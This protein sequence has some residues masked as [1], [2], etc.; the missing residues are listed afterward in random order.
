MLVVFHTKDFL[1]LSVSRN[2]ALAGVGSQHLLNF[3]VDLGGIFLLRSVFPGAMLKR[4]LSDILVSP[5]GRFAAG[6][7]SNIDEENIQFMQTSNMKI[8]IVK[9]TVNHISHS[10]EEFR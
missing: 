1:L 4:H 9:V 3:V 2:F 10:T 5:A 7:L 6:K 8:P